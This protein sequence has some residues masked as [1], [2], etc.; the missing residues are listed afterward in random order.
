[1]KKALICAASLLAGTG[2]VYVLV[3]AATAPEQSASGSA[4]W[5]ES[6]LPISQQCA[7]CHRKEYDEWAGSHHAWAWRHID[8]AKDTAPFQGQIVKGHGVELRMQLNKEGKPE[9]QDLKT[10]KIYTVDSVAG[11]TPLIQYLVRGEDGGLQCPSAAWDV[12]KQE[13]FDVFLDDARL[14]ASGMA[15]RQP[16]DWGH[17]H[18]RGMNWNSQCAWCHMTGYDK[19][20]DAAT[21]RYASTW[22]EPGITCIQCHKLADKPDAED[23]CMISKMDRAISD[24]QHDDNCASCHARREELTNQF[25]VGDRFDD[26]FRLELPH[27]PGVFHPNAVQLEEDYC[28][29]GFRM[30]RMGNT[31]VTCYDCH[32]PHT[33]GLVFP[34]DDDQL[35]LQCHST[36]KVINGVM[37]PQV[38]RNKLCGGHANR[39]VDCHMPEMTYMG[40]D[41]RRD[42]ALHWPDPRMSMELGTPDPCLTCH[43]DKDHQ[44]GADYLEKRYG[45]RIAK[46]RPRF[47]AVAAAMKGANNAEELLT[48]YAKEEVSAW[49]AAI[50]QLLA[51]MPRTPEITKVGQAAATDKDPLVRAAAAS[52]LSPTESAPLLQ[53]PVRVVRHAAAWQQFPR[54][55]NMQDVTRALHEMKA[56][57]KLQ[58]DQPTGAMQLAMLADA[59]GNSTEAEAQYRRALK[60][61]PSSAVAHMD[62]A[63]FLA[64]RGRTMEALQ[65]ML[66]CTAAN[67]NNAEAQYRLGL[68][69]LEVGYPAPAR[70]ALQKAVNIDP[71]HRSARAILQQLRFK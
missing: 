19:K 33:G 35:C 9:M 5:D 27:V 4:H 44:W 50:L 20:Y 36:K 38:N 21:N 17:W 64:R 68:I 24:S 15:E 63:V 47:R 40:R 30:S 1:M 48:V 31:G 12:E 67:P 51:R 71:Q 41:P 65:Q 55:L 10:G 69:L 45:E 26:H 58:S 39:C 34:M 11:K 54:V 57:A 59:T 52:F 23:G 14:Q 46:Y 25:T 6:A 42:H 29:T 8:P 28:E 61:D 16:T 53:D 13:W 66:A 49:R 60:L 43:Q 62:L 56:T 18:G 70:A 32:N 37:A 3:S 7:A 2:M 22:K